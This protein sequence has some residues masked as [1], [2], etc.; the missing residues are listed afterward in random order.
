MVWAD[1]D[2]DMADGERLKQEFWTVANQSG[3]T[4]EQFDQVVSIRNVVR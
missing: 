4:V 1:L 3:I 2:H